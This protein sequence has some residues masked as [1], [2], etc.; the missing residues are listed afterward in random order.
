MNSSR[1]KQTEQEKVQ[2]ERIL[3]DYFKV[4]STEAEN[5]RQV[6]L[7]LIAGAGWAILMPILFYLRFGKIDGF[8]IDFTIFLVVLH[9][10]VAFGFLFQT[11]TKYHT[12][13]P[14]KGNL[15]D[16]IGAFWL[17]ACAFGP[18]LGWFV[19]TAFSPT[20]SSWRWQYLARMFF[21]VVLPLI[22][23]T[24]LLRYVRGK[25][26]L[27]ALPLLIVIT[28]LPVITCLWVIGDLHD[29]PTI[30]QIAF[31]RDLTGDLI[32]ERLDESRDWL[33]C[34]TARAGKPR[35]GEKLQVTWLPHTRRVLKITRLP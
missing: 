12:T 14:L 34:D 30:N 6:R 16:K 7:Y 8:A 31:K 5:K 19:T 32:C 27:I 11:R 29:G 3:A 25:A 1:Q 35:A 9:L 13:V 20:A 26:A 23:V 2:R 4:E 24:P 15:G 22:T 33:P 10:L 17:V 28:T 21:A 18:F